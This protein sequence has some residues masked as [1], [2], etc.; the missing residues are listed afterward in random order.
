[1]KEAYKRV[2]Y[3]LPGSV[4]TE[5]KVAFLYDPSGMRYDM[6][7]EEYDEIC[8]IIRTHGLYVAP[9]GI[10]GVDNA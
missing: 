1:M 7:Q 5:F 9:I 8:W 10:L 2:V 4:K 3:G 6:R